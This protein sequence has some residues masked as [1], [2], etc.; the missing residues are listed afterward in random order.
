MVFKREYYC[1][2]KLISRLELRLQRD[3]WEGKF[4]KALEQ[5][6]YSSP[7]LPGRVAESLSHMLK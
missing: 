4:N 2:N 6:A 3:L 1:R 7:A 5:L